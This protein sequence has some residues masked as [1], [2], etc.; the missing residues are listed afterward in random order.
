MARAG[1]G[2]LASHGAELSTSRE[3]DVRRGAV[4]EL[5]GRRAG[6]DDEAG[7][8]AVGDGGWA[9]VRRRRRDAAERRRAMRAGRT[10]WPGGGRRRRRRGR[11][12]LDGR[13]GL[14]DRGEIEDDGGGGD[15]RRVDRKV[16]DEQNRN[17]SIYIDQDPLVSAGNTSRD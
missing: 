3:D 11:D 4:D 6:L 15:D 12:E 5:D 14:G 7:R 1:Q 16:E 13:A 8:E 17:R 9:R 10:V 2:V